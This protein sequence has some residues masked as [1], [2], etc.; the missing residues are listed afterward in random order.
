MRQKLLT[1][2]E[3]GVKT[4]VSFDD[5]FVK[6]THNGSAS[7]YDSFV[8]QMLHATGMAFFATYD[9]T[10]G[11]GKEVFLAE[12]YPVTVRNDYVARDSEYWEDWYLSWG[13]GDVYAR[14]RPAGV[15]HD[16]Q[17]HITKTYSRI[18]QSEG[19]DDLSQ[20]VSHI[21]LTCFLFMR[22]IQKGS[23]ALTMAQ[24]LYINNLK[25]C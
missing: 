16:F 1:K 22:K 3:S 5:T 9:K 11:L 13:A 6:E 20:N 18:G 21:I 2:H 25:L 8:A 4:S 23:S 14:Y 19:Q 7:D 15:A 24:S 17:V 12:N 10:R